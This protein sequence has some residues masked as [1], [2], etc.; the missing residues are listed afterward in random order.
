MIA[1]NV[2]VFKRKDQRTALHTSMNYDDN[3]S[4]ISQARNLWVSVAE[5]SNGK[6][7]AMLVIFWCNYAKAI[8]LFT[9]YLYPWKL[10]DFS[11]GFT[12]IEW[13]KKNSKV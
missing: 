5:I 13:L 4:P 6:F 11:E 10:S 8:L 3:I 2:D 9:E 12:D 1:A 7:F